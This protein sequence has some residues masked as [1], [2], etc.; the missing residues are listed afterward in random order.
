MTKIWPTKEE[1]QS[2]DL[3][4]KKSKLWLDQSLLLT[5]RNST[6]LK[7][8]PLLALAELSAQFVKITIGDTPTKKPHVV[9]PI[10]MD[11]THSLETDSERREKKSLSLMPGRVS[12]KALPPLEFPANLSTDTLSS[13]DGET[14]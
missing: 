3:Q 8:L 14:T 10:A 1:I 5:Q 13:L 12:S 6:Q 9:I 7:H 4:Q 11:S 2:K